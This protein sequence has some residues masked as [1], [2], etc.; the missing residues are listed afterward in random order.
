MA[1][2][3]ACVF[4]SPLSAPICWLEGGSI[5][6]ISYVDHGGTITWRPVISDP[7]R[8]VIVRDTYAGF[9]M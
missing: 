1:G 2:R 5:I 4:S 6:L 9:F 3:S 7:L 8:A